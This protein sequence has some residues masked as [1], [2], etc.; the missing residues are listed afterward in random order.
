[1]KAETLDCLKVALDV[2][3]MDM[4]GMCP[5]RLWHADFPYL[6]LDA[7]VRISSLCLHLVLE[8]DVAGDSVEEKVDSKV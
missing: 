2:T 4:S 7:A 3:T 1:M 6:V 5:L 8:E